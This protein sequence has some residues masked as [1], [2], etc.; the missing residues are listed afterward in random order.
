MAGLRHYRC[1]LLD[2]QSHIVAAEDVMCADDKAAKSRARQILS[3]KPE[4]PSIEVWARS[5][6]AHSSVVRS[7]I[8][9]RNRR[10]QRNLRLGEPGKLIKSLVRGHT[11]QK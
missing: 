5:P 4:F 9:D 2:A 1:Y 3:E 11:L 10:S 6:R 7:R 8:P